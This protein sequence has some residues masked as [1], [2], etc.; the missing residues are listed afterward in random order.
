MRVSTASS[1]AV[2]KV[3]LIMKCAPSKLWSTGNQWRTRC[4]I[5]VVK[6]IQWFNQTIFY[7]QTI[8]EEV[9]SYATEKTY[10]TKFSLFLVYL[11]LISW[12][13]A[14]WKRNLRFFL[15]FNHNTSRRIQAGFWRVLGVLVTWW[16]LV[17]FWKSRKTQK[18]TWIISKHQ[19]VTRTPETLR[20]L[21]W[22]PLTV[23]WLN[24]EKNLRFLFVLHGPSPTDNFL[25]VTPIA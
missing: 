12:A 16:C 5:R 13:L 22:N 25:K 2:V 9:I 19:K 1:G 24:F 17:S 3:T 10:H 18:I 7:S 15:N 23:F 8:A 21:T 20:K 4:S 11:S 6:A 14:V